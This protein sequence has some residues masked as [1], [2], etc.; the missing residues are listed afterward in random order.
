MNISDI[1]QLATLGVL[2]FTLL[3]LIYQFRSSI[4]ALR[5][6]TTTARWNL[7]LSVNERITQDQVDTML[8]HLADHID[9]SIYYEYYHGH[10]D[11][12]KSYLLMKRKYIYILYTIHIARGRG[13]SNIW[14]E[15]SDNIWIKELCQYYEF[16]HVHES[17]RHY[18]PKFA[19]LVDSLIEKTQ[20]TGWMLDT[21]NQ[22]KTKQS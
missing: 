3:I 5:T 7:Y 1:I 19:Q 15:I 22:G 18:Y 16:R 4:L 10:P 9:L 13:I 6:A 12:I 21:Y 17:Q 11:R 14:R 2:T 20:I 8:L